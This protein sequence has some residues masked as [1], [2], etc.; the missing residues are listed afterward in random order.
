MSNFAVNFPESTSSKVIVKL[1]S[2]QFVNKIS[3]FTLKPQGKNFDQEYIIFLQPVISDAEF[4]NEI[5]F[6]N[7]RVQREAGDPYKAEIEALAKKSRRIFLA[8]MFIAALFGIIIASVIVSSAS[9]APEMWFGIFIGW[10]V[11]PWC[12]CC[13]P[14]ALVYVSKNYYKPA[15]EACQKRNYAIIDQEIARL[16]AVYGKMRNVQFRYNS[17]SKTFQTGATGYTS[18]TASGGAYSG[19]TTMT[20]HH[21]TETIEFVEVLIAAQAGYPAPQSGYAP[22]SPYPP[23]GY[24]PPPAGYAPPLPGYAPPAGYAPSPAGYAPPTGY[25]PPPTG[26]A[27][28]PAGYAPPP[29]APYSERE[30]LLP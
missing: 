14:C 15:L 27:H 5:N 26:Y 9:M 17:K 21:K 13:G 19:S 16:N 29:T 8:S 1:Q 20:M 23:A 3:C 22:P 18:G 25:A 28:P 12:C 24:A 6:I 10:S 2:I 7:Q 11:A 4:R 30:R